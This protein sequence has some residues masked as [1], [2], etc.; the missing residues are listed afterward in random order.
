MIN[1]SYNF[2]KGTVVNTY[3]LA[4]G[5]IG[6]KEFIS[7][8]KQGFKDTFRK[9]FD[10]NLARK[11]PFTYAKQIGEITAG[12]EGSIALGAATKYLF[13]EVL[14]PAFKNACSYV[15]DKFANSSIGSKILGK[16]DDS[17]AVSMGG[18]EGEAGLVAESEGVYYHST[19]DVNTAEA[20]QTGG[21]RTDIPSASEAWDSNGY[22][23]GVYLAD[24]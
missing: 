9:I 8:I 2:A 18:V 4:T 19:V 13:R 15:V 7:G 14:V 20:I 22:G 1:G 21:F 17:G 5:Q 10:L 16:L 3:R 24:S 23:S 11:D 6:P 12:I